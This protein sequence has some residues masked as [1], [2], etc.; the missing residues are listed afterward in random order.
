M[1]IDHPRQSLLTAALHPG[2]A[3][4]SGTP[5]S[6]ESLILP[7]AGE[8]IRGT[9]IER[10]NRFICIVRT[11]SKRVEAHLPNTGRLAELLVKGR[12]V[13]LVRADSL[14]SLRKEREGSTTENLIPRGRFITSRRT[15][16][17]LI[18]VDFDGVLVS[19]DTTLPNTLFRAFQRSSLF[20]EFAGEEILKREVTFGRSRFDFLLGKERRKRF[21]EVKS[22]TLVEDG[23]ALFPD[24]VTERGK[25]HLEDL[26]LARRK[27]YDSACLF[28]IQRSDA[29]SFGPNR[30]TDPAYSKTLIQARRAG[31]T[32]AC[33]ALNVHE[34]SVSL[35]VPVPLSF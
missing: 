10:S 12:E 14:L 24:A 22:V 31:I 19:V 18:M 5:R 9:F 21:V 35:D 26:I 23:A 25:R 27:G 15:K 17:T 34:E 2:E 6:D 29:V 3:G 28:I 1:R 11:G 8:K 32:I 16:F 4:G 30:E 20:K 13:V 7:I 33:Y